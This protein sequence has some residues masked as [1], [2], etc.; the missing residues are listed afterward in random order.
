VSHHLYGPSSYHCVNILNNFGAACILRNRFEIAKRYLEIGIE[1]VLYINE[2][3]DIIVGYYCNYAEALFHCGEID[4]ALKYAEK[5]VTF[6]KSAPENLQRY[7]KN[8][9]KDV[10]RDQ[11]KAREGLSHSFLLKHLFKR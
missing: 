1:R 8:Y 5:A 3:S 2:C 11:W 9:L 6:S 10:K 4:E 7:A